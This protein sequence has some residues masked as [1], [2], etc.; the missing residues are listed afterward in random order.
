MLVGLALAV[1]LPAGLWLERVLSDRL[2]ESRVADLRGSLVR[3]LAAG[4]ATVSLGETR[5]RRLA[6]LLEGTVARDD[7]R[8]AAEFDR[9]TRRAPDGT[10]RLA[11]RLDPSIDAVL[12]VPSNHPLDQFWKGLLLRG[13]TI[14]SQVGSATVGEVADNVWFM[15]PKG[16]ELMYVPSDSNYAD[17][18]IPEGYDLSRWIDP[19]QPENNPDRRPKWLTAQPSVRPPLWFATVVAPVVRRGVLVGVAGFD[20][21][22]GRIFSEFGRLPAGPG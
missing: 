9:V 12:W 6:G 22:I 8:D 5:L 16:A 20:F 13:Q 18:S 2:I 1:L 10:T 14:V 11:R 21:S 19:V 7:A 17:Q 3:E 4:A 15:T